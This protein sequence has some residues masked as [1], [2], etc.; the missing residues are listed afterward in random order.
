M[1]GLVSCSDEPSDGPATENK[2]VGKWKASQYFE[3][4]DYSETITLEFKKNGEFIER[5]E[6]SDG[7]DA[8]RVYGTWEIVSSNEES[9]EI[10]LTL[11]S[12]AGSYELYE[13]TWHVT[14]TALIKDGKLFLLNGRS[15]RY[16]PYPEIPFTKK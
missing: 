2:L 15:D 11:T 1:G 7:E 4:D 5:T 13:V 3:E 10:L 6:Y 8:D 9:T 12:P 16:K 14:Y